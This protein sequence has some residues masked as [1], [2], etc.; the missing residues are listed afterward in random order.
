MLAASTSWKGTVYGRYK[1]IHTYDVVYTVYDYMLYIESL[2]FKYVNM[3]EYVHV[4]MHVWHDHASKLIICVI[5][6][7]KFLQF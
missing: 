6:R 4:Y 2:T 7:A 3:I 5:V 1:H